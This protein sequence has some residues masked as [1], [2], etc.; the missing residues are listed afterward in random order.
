MCSV[1]PEPNDI[2]LLSVVFWGSDWINSCGWA[3]VI[4]WFQEGPYFPPTLR[5]RVDVVLHALALGEDVPNLDEIWDEDGELYND[6]E[7][8]AGSYGFSGSIREA[9][10]ESF[11]TALKIVRPPV[12]PVLCPVEFKGEERQEGID[13]EDGSETNDIDELAAEGGATGYSEA[14][15]KLLQ[16]MWPRLVRLRRLDR[17]SRE[18]LGKDVKREVEREVKARGEE[19]DRESRKRKICQAFHKRWGAHTLN[20]S[21]LGRAVLIYN[22]SLILPRTP[23]F[24]GMCI[25]LE[26]LFYLG[27]WDRDKG[28]RPRQAMGRR[29][30]R[31]LEEGDAQND[32]WRYREQAE[33][34]YETRN[35]V[36]HGDVLWQDVAERTVEIGEQL[37]RKSLQKLLANEEWFLL[38][39]RE[40]RADIDRKRYNRALFERFDG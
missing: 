22:S 40:V 1:C 16:C 13:L 18:Q 25:V 3:L 33:K 30:A 27:R 35:G 24:L 7:R 4:K 29:L 20:R 39:S 32:Y 28:I 2:G 11:V 5:R 10:R 21:R 31:L 34:V 19:S 9:F 36:V 15:R 26:T 37:A 8:V 17:D 38:F 12:T 6:V 14:D 23:R